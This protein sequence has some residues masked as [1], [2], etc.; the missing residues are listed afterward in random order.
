MIVLIKN[1][2]KERNDACIILYIHGNLLCTT[3]RGKKSKHKRLSQ[4]YSSDPRTINTTMYDAH[5]NYIQ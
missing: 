3:V 5:N 2:E 1:I 4:H